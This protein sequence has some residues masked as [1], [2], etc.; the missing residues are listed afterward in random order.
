MRRT[1]VRA[2]L[3]AALGALLL[4]AAACGGDDDESAADTQ[5][6]AA[7]TTDDAETTEAETEAEETEEAEEPDFA[8][9]A[10]CKEFT[11][12]GQKVSAALG[13]TEGAD[14][15]E[16]KE[17]LN[18]FADDAPEEIRD[19][20][21][22]IADAYSKIADALAD[23]QLE[24]GETPDP[25]DALKLQEIAGEIDQAALTEANTNITTW[26]NENCSSG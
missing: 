6:A 10:N 21:R 25:E 13:G 11:E 1:A 17:L 2:I 15:D 18:E 20:F 23:L 8:N 4:A 12:L 19:D 5:A 9:A 16:T 26:V 24:P 22:V 7:A 3:I 14:A